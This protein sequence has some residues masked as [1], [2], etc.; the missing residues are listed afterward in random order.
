MKARS[1]GAFLGAL[2]FGLLFPASIP[3]QNIS[4]GVRGVVLDATHAAIPGARVAGIRSRCCP[5]AS[6][7]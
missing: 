2:V 5:P 4:A 3:A 1:A 6:I 7:R